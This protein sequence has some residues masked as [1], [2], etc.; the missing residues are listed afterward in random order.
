[1]P[2]ILV[3]GASGSNGRELIKRL[4]AAGVPARG[5]VRKPHSAATDVLPGVEF[6]TADFD[7]AAS[8]AERLRASNARSS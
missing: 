3:T 7:D 4:A 1:M 5:M 2:M 8:M 6:V